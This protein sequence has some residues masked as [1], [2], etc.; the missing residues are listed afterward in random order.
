MTPKRRQHSDQFTFKVVLEAAKGLKTIGEHNLHT[1][2]VS[3]VAG[4]DNS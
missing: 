1:N 3:T 4:A 2:L